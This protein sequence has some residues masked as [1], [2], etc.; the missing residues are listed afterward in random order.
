[1]APPAAPLLLWLAAAPWV[2]P[3]FFAL[4]PRRVPPPTVA[5]ILCQILGVGSTI[6]EQVDSYWPRLTELLVDRATRCG[7]QRSVV[8]VQAELDRL[9]HTTRLRPPRPLVWSEWSRPD[10]SFLLPFGAPRPTDRIIPAYW[11]VLT[12]T[13]SVD[14]DAVGILHDPGVQARAQKVETTSV[15]DAEELM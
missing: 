8:V 13:R 10:D 12:S 9:Y 3:V 4:A 11:Y 5:A 1:M 7:D 6:T 2:S 15:D 14:P